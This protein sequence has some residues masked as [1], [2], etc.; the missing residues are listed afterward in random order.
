MDY[1]AARGNPPGGAPS[2][3]RTGRPPAARARALEGPG[4]PA[5]ARPVISDRDVELEREGPEPARERAPQRPP[6]GAL[7]RIAAGAGNRAFAAWVARSASDGHGA[8]LLPGGR[9]HPDVEATIAA[10]RGGGTAL[11]AGVQDRLSGSLGP[12]SD[13]RV[14]T[15][16]TADSLNRAVSARAFAT[17]NDVFFAQGE[18]APGS[19]EGDRLIAHEMT[20]VVQ[21][22]GAPA[23]GPLRVTE[24]GDATEREADAVADGLAP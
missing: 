15:D 19:G 16:A 23:S 4:A 17:G 7:Q 3:V 9:V 8:G 24:P 14:H 2:R 11:D 10:T 1:A 6:A 20:H 12:L 13:V 21:Q 22:R 18:Y 5:Y